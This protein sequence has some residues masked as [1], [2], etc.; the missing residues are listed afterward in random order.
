MQIILLENI[1]NLGKKSQ[2]INVKSGYA[3]NF[4][5]PKGKCISATKN[6]INL[7]KKQLLQLKI[8]SL[9]VFK[10]AELRLKKFN[11]INKIIIKSKAGKTGRLFGSIGRKDIVNKLKEMGFDILKKEIKLPK[12]SLKQIGDYSVSFH[13]HEKIF[14]EKIVSII[15]I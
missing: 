9:N 12:G 1:P 15:N 8:Q 5:I 14:I 7:L 3:R 6:N 13:F 11:N 10:N 2:I 4:L